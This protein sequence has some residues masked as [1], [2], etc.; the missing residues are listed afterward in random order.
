MTWLQA[1]QWWGAGRHA[2][3]CQTSHNLQVTLKPEE[4]KAA[5]ELRV[6][7]REQADLG[8]D[9]RSSTDGWVTLHKSLTFSEPS[10]L[11]YKAEREQIYTYSQGL[12]KLV[13]EMCFSQCLAN[14]KCSISAC[15][16]KVSFNRIRCW[17]SGQTHQWTQHTKCC[18]AW[19]EEA[20]C[21]ALTSR[22]HWVYGGASGTWAA[23]RPRRPVRTEKREG[24]GPWATLMSL[25]P[26]TPHL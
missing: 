7:T 8:P 20:L 2:A 11:F 13:H 4:G 14:S 12:S 25:T 18:M 19:M 17:E 23:H 22:C 26:V 10:F 15:W 21:S 9:F 24:K 6:Y 1:S 3:S 16:T 5:W